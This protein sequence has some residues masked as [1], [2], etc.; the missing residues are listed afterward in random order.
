MLVKLREES[1]E[2]NDHDTLI[3]LQ[4]IQQEQTKVLS[5]IQSHVAVMNEEQGTQAIEIAELGVSM[6]HIETQNWFIITCVAGA[7]I[8][9]FV[10]AIIE[11]KQKK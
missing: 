9:Y 1:K 3:Q 2:M 7:V 6:K 4:T 10:K 11:A 8:T 5:D